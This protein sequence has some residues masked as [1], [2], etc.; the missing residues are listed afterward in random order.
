MAKTT[1]K[2][3]ELIVMLCD[4]LK[5]LKGRGSHA[6]GMSRPFTS[7]SYVSLED[8]TLMFCCAVSQRYG[9]EPTR[10]WSDFLPELLLCHP[11]RC[12][13]VLGLIEREQ[14]ESPRYFELAGSSR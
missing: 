7:D 4:H 10:R 1:E 13:E 9:E 5:Q 2:P 6:V 3:R 14:F 8:A 12:E 11:E